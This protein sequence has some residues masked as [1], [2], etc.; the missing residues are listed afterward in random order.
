MQGRITSLDDR[1]Q[2]ELG[3]VEYRA[4]KV[5]TWLLPLYTLGW[6][7]VVGLAL[8]PY[9]AVAIPNKIRSAQDQPTDPTWWAIFETLSAYSNTGFNLLNANMIRMLMI[10]ANVGR[11]LTLR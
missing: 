8:V 2:E 6:L 1:Q 5:L 3:G 4:L 7:L 10:T 9:A 11:L